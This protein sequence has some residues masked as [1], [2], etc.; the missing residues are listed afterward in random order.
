M[1]K[2][3]PSS[4]ENKSDDKIL[5][6][7]KTKSIRSAINRYVQDLGRDFEK[8]RGKDFRTS[9]SILDGKLK[10]NLQEAYTT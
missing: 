10:T 3:A 8:V 4:Q 1:Q 5:N 6:I 9:N 2:Q 7:T